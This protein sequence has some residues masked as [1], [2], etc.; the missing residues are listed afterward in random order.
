MDVKVEYQWDALFFYTILRD[1]R[2]AFEEV[3]ESAVAA[4]G[5]HHVW[6]NVPGAGRV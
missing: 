2:N 1:R 6:N 5:L 4:F 3:K